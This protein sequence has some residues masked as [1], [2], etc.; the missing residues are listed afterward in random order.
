[1]GA[2]RFLKRVWK[3]AYDF[4]INELEI[5]SVKK[6]TLNNNQKSLRRHLHKTIIK[7]TDD[8]GRRNTFNTA[9]AAIMELMNHLSKAPLDSI[10][11]KAVMNEAIQAVVLMLTPIVP[12]ITHHLW[13]LVGDITNGLTVEEASWPKADE[14]ALIEDEKLI[15]V[16]VNGKVRTKITI[17]ADADQAS[18]EKLAFAQEQ[19]SK[20][21]EDKTVRKVIYVAGKLLN[22]VAN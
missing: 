4:S 20:F 12:H 5:I 3:L 2:H 1:E 22:I 21:T 14:S 13:S 11:D 10:E 19:V 18:I 9:I 8:I 7:V 15:I 17:A 6:L 16:Q